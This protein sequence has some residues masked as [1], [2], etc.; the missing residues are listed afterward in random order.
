MKTIVKTLFLFFL[1][2]SVFAQSVPYNQE[3]Q[4][5]SY[6]INDQY[7]PSISGLSDGGFVVCWSSSWQDSSQ[8][9]IY[10]QLYN[11]DGSKKGSEFKANSI[12]ENSQSGSNVIALNDGGFVVSWTS[13]RSDY[14]DPVA[15]IKIFNND[16]S[17]RHSEFRV[18]TITTHT[19]EPQVSNL[20]DDKFVLC[21]GFFDGI[22]NRHS[23]RGKIFN[24]DG[25]VVGSDFLIIS[26]EFPVKLKVSALVDNGFIAIWQKEDMS[27]TLSGFYYQVYNNDGSKRSIVLTL[28]T[29]DLMLNPSISGLYGGGFIVCWERHYYTSNIFGQLFDAEGG[30]VGDEFKVNTNTIWDQSVPTVKGLS[31]GR[32]FVCWK[33]IINEGGLENWG[34]VFKTDGSSIGSEFWINTDFN[35]NPA[36]NVS[37]LVNNGF[38]VCWEN[39]KEGDNG[40]E[41]Y[42]KYFNNEIVHQLMPFSLTK[43]LYDES[44]KTLE[45]SFNWQQASFTRINLPYELEYNI[46]LD[47]DE[48]FTSPRIITQY[49]DTSCVIDSLIPG[50]T[51]F[52]KVLAK[53]IE[54]D[55]LWSSEINAFFVDH[56]ATPIDEIANDHPQSFQL[57]ANYPNPFNPETTTKYSLP[58]GQ[59]VYN[60][61]VK[62]Y[63]ALGQ[64]IEVLV[65]SNQKPGLYT[66]KWNASNVPSGVYF[67]RIEAGQFSA[68]QKM[69]LVR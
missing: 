32:F 58:P 31:D 63:N 5:N 29:H 8:N 54:G 6:Q 25:S 20:Y 16:G 38:V 59:S 66:I 33:S 15:Y 46:Y 1:C 62:I 34:Q 49:A 47:K 21:W 52:W 42:C 22:T 50:T 48:N 13:T 37:N 40:K 43:P 11:S 26:D 65:D 44:I 35:Y 17:V 45:M 39:R 27:G 61:K 10:C 51:Y 56:N 12:H 2:S 23:Y 3:F 55:S 60:V 64:L 14:F 9:S 41:V 67:C 30:K 68:T 19:W 18:D 36:P 4:V 57:F 53:N 24:S 7:E 69:L 28:N